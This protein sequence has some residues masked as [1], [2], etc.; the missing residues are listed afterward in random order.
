MA[1]KDNLANDLFEWLVFTSEITKSKKI[2]Y[3]SENNQLDN[4][5]SYVV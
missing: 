2:E 1:V 4:Y 3:I 5:Y